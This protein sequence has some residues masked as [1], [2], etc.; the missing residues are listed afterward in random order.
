MPIANILKSLD[1]PMLGKQVYRTEDE[2]L[3]NDFA[4]ANGPMGKGYDATVPQEIIIACKGKK[5]RITGYLSEGVKL[6]GVSDWEPMVNA[7]G[8][9]ALKRGLDTVNT[10]GQ[11][12]FGGNTKG[13]GESTGTAVLQPW[14]NRQLWK[15]SKPFSLEFNFNLVAEESSKDDV[16][17]PAQALL[18]F[19]YPRLVNNVELVEKSKEVMAGAF[20]DTMPNGGKTVVGAAKDAINTYATPGPSLM[21]GASG[22]KGGEN[23]NG[24]AVTIVIGNMFA[25]GACYLKSVNIE[26]SPNMDYTGYPVWCK[27]SVTAEAMDSNF[28][29]PDGSFLISQWADSA[30]NVSELVKALTTT[31]ETLA[32]NTA[33]VAKATWNAISAFPSILSKE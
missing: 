12:G 5:R 24:D 1:V 15:G 14:M 22:N 10:L 16:F 29:N 33:N 18:S 20:N 27:C 4:M 31:V 7:E 32:K 21:Y 28:C 19:C 3:P 26:F 6:N 11:L 9:S 23:D 17:L 25:F 2:F 13:G 30:S 8:I